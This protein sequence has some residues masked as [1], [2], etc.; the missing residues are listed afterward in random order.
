[1]KLVVDT[2]IVFSALLNA[3][4]RMVEVLLNPESAFDFFAPDYLRIELQKY[5][6]KLGDT[7]NLSAI[8][9]REASAKIID[10]LT[11]I[12]ESL[13]SENSWN[14]AFELTNDI[15]EGDTPFVA[16]AIDLKC[17][18]WTGDKK[19]IKGLID[20]GS[21]VAIDTKQLNA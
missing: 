12:S 7:S 8:N 21:D 18:L 3:N 20:K 13:I 10:R 1:M 14:E 15:D 5:E 17:K 11:L 9:L 16:L 19:L 6:K 4:N 2:N